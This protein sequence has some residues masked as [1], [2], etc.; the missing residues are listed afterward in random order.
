[1]SA[2]CCEYVSEYEQ[3]HQQQ[4]Y[5]REKVEGVRKR[6]GYNERKREREG[7]RRKKGRRESKSYR[8]T[9]LC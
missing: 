3:K 7:E 8:Q 4:M 9:L 6:E 5:K 1:M 2:L